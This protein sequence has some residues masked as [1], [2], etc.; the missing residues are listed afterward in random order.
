[1]NREIKVNFSHAR[2]SEIAAIKKLTDKSFSTVARRVMEQGILA[3]KNMS[4]DEF[5]E[6]MRT[7][8]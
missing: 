1:M 2:L 7:K 3:V 5:N 8:S 6:L 4:A